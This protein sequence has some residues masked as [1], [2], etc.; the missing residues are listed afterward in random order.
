MAVNLAAIGYYWREQRDEFNWLKHLVI[1]V[2]GFILMI[3]AFLGV[4]AA[5]PSR[6]WT[7]SSIRWRALFI[8]AAARRV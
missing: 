6:S 3:P 8:R 2:I 4:L 1:P 7:S 5:S